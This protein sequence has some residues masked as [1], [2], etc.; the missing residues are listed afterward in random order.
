MWYLLKECRA[1]LDLQCPRW[2]YLILY[3]PVGHR[4]N[5]K[6]AN[7]RAKKRRQVSSE[8]SSDGVAPKSLSYGEKVELP[9]SA[10]DKE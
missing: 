2:N 3:Q 5:A 7:S 9:E 4:K 8:T 1:L 6:A 10:D